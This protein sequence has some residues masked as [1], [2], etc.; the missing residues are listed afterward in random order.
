MKLHSVCILACMTAASLVSPV[1]FGQQRS[2]T[3]VFTPG[4][5]YL[6]IGGVDITPDRAHALNLKEERGV[7]ISSVD[8]EGPA[9]KAGL[10]EGD[11]VLEFNGQPVEGWAQ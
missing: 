5:S 11:V 1:A 2:Q 9:A 4:G 8:P 3:F 10:K 6:G 7:E